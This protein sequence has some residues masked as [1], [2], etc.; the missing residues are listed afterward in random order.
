MATVF[1]AAHSAP[2]AHAGIRDLARAAFADGAPPPGP[3]LLVPTPPPPPLPASE[4]TAL[5]RSFAAETTS[6]RTTAVGMFSG[7]FASMPV[8]PE[9]FR[10]ASR[11]LAGS[12]SLRAPVMPVLTSL[13][14]EEH[15]SE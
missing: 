15:T 11:S 4:A 8:I 12:R 1:H 2:D 5:A 9:K 3:P 10:A 14:S 7:I 6:E 13:R